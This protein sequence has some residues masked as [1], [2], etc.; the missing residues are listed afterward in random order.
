MRETEV[1]LDRWC[2]GGLG[3]QRNDS[4][5]RATMRGI[6]KSVEPWCVSN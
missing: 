3:R 5:G 6:G 1:R 2:E 4:G